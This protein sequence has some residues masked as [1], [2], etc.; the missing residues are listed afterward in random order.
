M[1]LDNPVSGE[2][3]FSLG[4][5]EPEILSYIKESMVVQSRISP[6]KAYLL[7]PIGSG[8]VSGTINSPFTITSYI[9]TT[10]QYRSIIWAS[11]SNHP[12]IRP[13]TNQGKG[14]ITVII[15]STE[16]TRVIDVEDIINDNEFA[17]VKRMDLLSA[18]VELVFNEG[19]NAAG[20]TIQ[21]Y[22]TT[23]ES[24]VNVERMKS[25]EGTFDSL[26]GW[27]QYLDATSDI[28]R[29]INQILIRYPLSQEDL[30]VNEEGR[31]T[32][33]QA[34][35]WTIWTPR[36]FNYD[37]LVVTGDQTF[38]GEEERYEV[39]DK[40]DSRIQGTLI[41]QRFKLRYIESSDPRYSIAV[42]TT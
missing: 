39:T 11:G 20:A 19:F 38:S 40:R 37:I 9:E 10:P 27:S 25:G 26:F 12:D 41:T 42:A 23:L 8:S 5:Q 32:L 29:G 33:E 22:Y 28:F 21:Y 14:S 4:A 1:G 2:Y 17:V 30:I 24:G 36:L 7:Q 6:I 31:V 35:C 16:A 34:D 15:N 3:D 13:Y 18:R